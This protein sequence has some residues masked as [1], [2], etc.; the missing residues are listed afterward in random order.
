MATKKSKRDK[1][2]KKARLSDKD[3]IKLIKKLRPKNQQIVRVNVGDKADKKGSGSVNPFGANL[4]PVRTYAEPFQQQQPFQPPPAPAPLPVNQQPLLKPPIPPFVPLKV[5][6]YQGFAY[7]YESEAE[8]P[9]PVKVRKTRTSRT[10]RKAAEDFPAAAAEPEPESR[11]K[12]PRQYN[13]STLSASS[14]QPSF[15]QPPAQNDRYLQPI[16]EDTTRDSAGVVAQPATSDEWTGTPEG[17]IA[18]EP[19]APVE[20]AAAATVEPEPLETAPA[21]EETFVGRPIGAQSAV[22]KIRSISAISAFAEEEP[23]WTQNIKLAEILPPTPP[24]PTAAPVA[25]GEVDPLLFNR[26]YGFDYMD[27]LVRDAPNFARDLMKDEIVQKL[28]G[29]FTGVPK[30]FLT[31]TGRLRT[32]L[33]VNQLFN[34]YMDL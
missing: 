11:F 4:V 34:L 1:K 23:D 19:V 29:G 31:K 7:P 9:T 25:A 5:P 27:K 28:K 8:P 30:E 20:A 10:S 13:E 21:P 14:S 3:I 2:R 6:P 16:F 24:E 22:D 17:F 12:A 33:D 32:K 18:E 15:F 26:L